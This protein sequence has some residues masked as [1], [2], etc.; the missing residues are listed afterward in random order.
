MTSL[1]EDQRFP[2]DPGA[3]PRALPLVAKDLVDDVKTLV[4]QEID[5]AKAEISQTVAR[6]AKAGAMFAV[7]GVLALYL[8]GFA[9]GTIARAL[10]GPLPDWAAWLIVTGLILVL[11]VVL[12]LVGKNF[13]PSGAPGQAAKEELDATKKVVQQRLSEAQQAFAND[14]TRM[15]ADG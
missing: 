14:A 10:E 6:A 9:F 3:P 2:R 7:A 1:P 5:L 13:L 15:P 8:L 11:I 4:S 12:A